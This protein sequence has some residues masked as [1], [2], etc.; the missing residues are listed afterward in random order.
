VKGQSLLQRIMRRVDKALAEPFFLD[1]W[2][3][4]SGRDMDYRSLRWDS[5]TPIL[6]EKDR[7]WGDPFVL[8]R[9]GKYFVFAEEKLYATG[10]GRIACLELDTDGRCQS[11]R[12]VL[13]RDYHLSYPFVFEYQ[14]EVLMIPETAARRTVELYRCVDFPDKWEFVRFLLQDLYAVDPTLLE[15]AGRMWLFANVKKP[16]GSSLD[17]LHLYSA[18]TPWAEKWIPHPRNP[19]VHDIRS[20]RPAG[21]VFVQDGV[22]IRPSQDSASRYGHAL[23][24]NRITRL[25]EEGYQEETVARFAPRGGMFRATHT[26][27]QAGALTVIDAVIRRRR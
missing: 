20:A 23:N 25:D 4:L 9:D 7:Y 14:G 13:E 26:F 12:V 27:N 5:F 6:P 2:V 19:V 1:Q 16:G 15:H 3:I 11:Q 8:A 21:R 10:R 17:A 18:E 24:F 22:L